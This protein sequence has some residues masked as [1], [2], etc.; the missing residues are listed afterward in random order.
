ME[1]KST[2]IESFPFPFQLSTRIQLMS[3]PKKEKHIIHD[4]FTQSIFLFPF[5]V[6]T[7]ILRSK[8]PQTKSEAE[9]GRSR[10]FLIFFGLKF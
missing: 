1:K 8:K 7:S 5:S 6:K 4:S 3:P 2:S 9:F 10:N